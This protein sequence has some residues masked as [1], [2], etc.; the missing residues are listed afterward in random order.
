MKTLDDA[1]TWYMAV[2][3]GMRRLSHL[4]KYWGELPWES[5][6]VWVVQL[7]ADSVLRHLEAK[8]LAGDAKL[9]ADE[10]DDLAILV[11]F[12]V[13]EATIRDL[14]EQQ[15]RPEVEQL[16]H[17]TLKAA[18]QEVLKGV[19][20]GSFYR[21]IEQVKS[22]D[23]NDL[24]E[25]VN[26]VRKYRNWVAHGRRAD[27]RPSALVRPKDAYD[28]LKEFLAIVRGPVPVARSAPEGE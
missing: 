23:N 7:A 27:M 18:G 1:W 11:L 19:A 8:P 15:V 6:D 25:Q 13:F 5:N 20:E 3:E 9:V 22:A 26:Q 4:A 17:V 16:R 10:V 12:S 21:V 2:K 24:V 14:L 28:R